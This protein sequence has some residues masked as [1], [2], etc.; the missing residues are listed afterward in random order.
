MELSLLSKMHIEDS[1]IITFVGAG[2]K[3]S[4]MYALGKE[5]SLHHKTLLTTTT[6]I[7]EPRD[8]PGVRLVTNE[9]QE[10]LVTAF[11]N[12]RLVALGI[13]LSGA[14]RRITFQF[15]R[16]LHRSKCC[17]RSQMGFA[18]PLFS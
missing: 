15:F 11:Q 13:P 2:G 3:T 4:L 1:R 7:M 9:N 16:Y 18:F 14:D 5:M 8:L 10:Q 12:S 6:H 17:P